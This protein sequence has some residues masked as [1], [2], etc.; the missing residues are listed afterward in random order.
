[1]SITKPASFT[2]LVPL[3]LLAFV[4]TLFLGFQTSLMVSDRGM[5]QDSIKQQQQPLEQAEKVKT[6]ANALA[7][8]TL[9]LAKEGNKDAQ[10]II[11]QM[12][13]AGIEVADQPQGAAPAA[14][15]GVGAPMTR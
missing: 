2:A 6:Q 8:G 13:K 10:M 4:V 3:A 15:P 5:L 12:K 14:A 11:D 1:M 7:V 9:R